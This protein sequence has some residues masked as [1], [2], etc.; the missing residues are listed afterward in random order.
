M[1]FLFNS[2]MVVGLVSFSLVLFYAFESLAE[3]TP[4]HK[5]EATAAEHKSGH[6]GGRDNNALFPPPKPNKELA[7]RPSK[8]ELTEPA[9]FAQISGAQVTLKWKAAAGATTYRLQVATDPNF[10][11][12]KADEAL[13]AGTSYD[14]KGLEAGKHYYWRVA[15]FKAD[16]TSSYSQGD[17]SK[18]M[19][20]TK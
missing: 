5:A 14:L 16:N 6:E 8:V 3:H 9:A 4:E 12:L 10:K 13:Y 15:G 17:F 20:E 19:F 11:W 1:N 18:S 2:K 7:T